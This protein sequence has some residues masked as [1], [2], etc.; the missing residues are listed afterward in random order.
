MHLFSNLNTEGFDA[1]QVSI[2]LHSLA[3]KYSFLNYTS[4]GNSIL[5]KEIPLITLGSGERSLLY[6]GAH[7]GMEWVTA[8]VLCAFL[9]ELCEAMKQAHSLYGYSIPL[10][11]STHTLALVP[12]LNPDGVSSQIH[13]IEPE[14][15]LYSRVLTMNGGDHDFSHWQANARGVDLNHNYDA[16]FWDYKSLELKNGIIQGAPTRYSG[17]A[18]ESE[19]EVAR[20]CNWIR[21]QRKLRG[22]LTLHTQG[23]EI[24][25]KSAEKAAKGSEAIAKKMAQW[26]G[27]RLSEAKGLASYGGL[28]DWCI[29]TL[30]IPSFT[31]EC[32]K[33]NNP[34]PAS[35]AISIYAS[36]RKS[37]FLFPTLV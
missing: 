6:V 4:L 19:P 18:P 11:L 33:G 35:Q 30:G 2:F 28:T 25:Y 14:N 13:G 7:H 36:L 21:F 3:Q 37:L 31:L 34:L 27:Y 20:L 16:G 1:E 26:S 22:V 10:L 32:G 17:E 5:G 12:M 29:Q 23:E 9:Q 24:Y 8:V 15:P